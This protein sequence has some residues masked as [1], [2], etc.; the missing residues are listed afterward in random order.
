MHEHVEKQWRELAEQ[1]VFVFPLAAGGKNPG[2]LGVKWQK[3]WVDKQRNPWPQ[4]A[5]AYDEAEGLWMATG[6]V[7]MRVVLDIDKPEAGDYWRDK[8][9]ADLFDRALRVST[10][11]G[12][13]LHFRIPPE[14]DR[15]WESHSDNDLGYDFRGDGGGVVI[16]PSVHASGRVYEWA[17]GELLD[18]PEALRH[19]AHT[20]PSNVKSLD[21]ARE[22][23]TPGSTLSGL[24]SDPPEEGGRNNWLTKVAGHLARLWPA[25][26]ADAYTELVRYIGATLPD[27]LEDAESLKTAESVWS[28][29]KTHTEG[30]ACPPEAGFLSAHNGKMYT[31]CKGEDGNIY[32]KEWANFDLAARRVVQEH[33]ERVFYVDIVAEHTT[34]A[35]E[36]LRADVL[37]NINRL[38]VW[39]AA[40]HIVIIGQ[41]TDLCKMSYGSRLIQY[42][43]HQNPPMAQIAEFY[44]H[45]DDGSFITPDGIVEGGGVAPFRSVIPAA[46]LSGWVGYRYG[47]C[48]PEEALSVLREVLTFQEETTASVFGSWWAMALLKGRFSSSLFPFML[49]EAGSESGKTT[50]FFAQMVALAGSKDGAGQ[51]TAASFRDAL[52][53]H[54]NGIAWL[55]DMTEVSTGQ[56]VDMI[57]QATGE[58]TRGKKGLD[59]KLTERVALRSPI[60][61]S[62]EG[63][64]TMMSEKAMSDRAVKLTFSSPKGRMSLRDPERPQW[65][66]VVAL[67]ERYGGTTGGLTAVSGTLVAMVLARASLLSSLASLRPP[68]AGR[69]ADK[70]AILRMGARVLADLTGDQSHVAR[71]DAWVEAQVDT[72][73]ANLMVNEIVPW[74]LRQG[75]GG[76]PTMAKGWVPAFYSPQ[77]GTVWVHSGQLADRWHERSNLSARERQLGTQAAIDTE[78]AALGAA[79]ARKTVEFHGK[80]EGGNVQKRYR[81]IPREWTAHILD[82]AGVDL[83]TAA[84]L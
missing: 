82:R 21:R 28:R 42:L 72:G 50:G 77:S 78:L 29:E 33:D 57:R 64:G 18:V 44:G 68:G 3:T 31:R 63:S 53:A 43:L 25:P 66:D 17:G 10:G 22:K 7:S 38:N 81:E 67:Q 23:K 30:L 8:I 1:G 47:T 62:G 74:V 51:H 83:G 65:D 4:L 26:M 13:H 39:L 37:G 16:P 12:Y 32:A 69:H 5:S 35:N 15:P 55:D 56:V 24:L 34:Y 46:Y 75:G 60:L 36:P 20:K 61:V 80:S 73:A 11:K 27:P 76:V 40:H 6:R 2:D 58:S 79:S 45:Q 84:A 48:P 41:P 19:P 14:D 49:L 9:G 70:M 52:A 59:N 71:V 54:R